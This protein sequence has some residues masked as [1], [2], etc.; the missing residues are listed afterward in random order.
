MSDLHTIHP[1]TPTLFD[2]LRK[3]CDAWIISGDKAT[4]LTGSGILDIVKRPG[5]IEFTDSI[6]VDWPEPRVMIFVRLN[7]G[8]DEVESL[9][10]KAEELIT[11]A[12]LVKL[13]REIAAAGMLIESLS[14]QLNE[15]NQD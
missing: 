15:L 1:E 4:R 2:A 5:A 9:P 14:R 7:A 3:T 10:G 11:R 13:Q 6:V 12:R 8:E